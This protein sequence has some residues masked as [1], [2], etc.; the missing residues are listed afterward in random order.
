MSAPVLAFEL[1]EALPDGRRL[2]RL[3]NEPLV[4]R[5]VVLH[6]DPAGDERPPHFEQVSLL[7]PAAAP[8]PIPPQSAVSGSP[9]QR[10]AQLLVSLLTPSQR[11]EWRSRGCFSVDTPYGRVELGR[12]SD[13]SFWP[14]S[15]G[16]YRLCVVPAGSNFLPDADIWVNLLL[17]L[18]DDPKRFLAV[19][20][21]R[22][23]CGTWHRGPV[24]GLASR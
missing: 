22:R 14:T 12:M 10:A 5:R 9:G 16:E 2:V 23:R 11:R 19:A 24:P 1:I 8:R 20:N 4:G 18:S 13:I 3:L 15:G 7:P 6:P 17:V 21:W